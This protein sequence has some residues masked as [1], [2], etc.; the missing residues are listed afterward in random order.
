MALAVDKEKCIGCA[1]CTQVCGESF[2]MGADGKA[3]AVKE[4]ACAPNAAEQCPVEAI[5]V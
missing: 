2:Q 4:S 5:T 1:S 3:E